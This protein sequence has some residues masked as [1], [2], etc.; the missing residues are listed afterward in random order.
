MLEARGNREKKRDVYLQ[1][2]KDVCYGVLLVR[3]AC[4]ALV[5]FILFVEV[6]GGGLRAALDF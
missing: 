6:A 1:L 5:H 2:K 3:K 4:N